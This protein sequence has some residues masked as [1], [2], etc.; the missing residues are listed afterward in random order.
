MS[1]ITSGKFL[2]KIA[3]VQ[4]GDDPDPVL[5][6]NGGQAFMRRLDP[7]RAER[8]ARRVARLLPAGTSFVLLGYDSDPPQGYS[9]DLIAGDVAKIISSRW[10][11]RATVIGISF[12][13]IVATRLV[14][15][16]PELVAKLVLLASAH[17]FSDQGHARVLA[18]IDCAERG[19]FQALVGGFVAVFRRRWLNALLRTRLWFDRNKLKQKMN[20]PQAIIRSLRAVIDETAHHGRTDLATIK[21]P[22][23]VIGGSEDQFFGGG[24]M[25]EA[26]SGMKHAQL[27]LFD[28][29]THMAPVERAKDIR[30]ILSG[31]L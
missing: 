27:K 17:R 8:D 22:T 21:T 24:A 30:A 23:L 2:D 31:F 9:L 19:D 28:Q 7:Q 25:Q 16:H 11:G 1:K 29:E 12:G 18:Q 13:G 10:H 6:L 26:A 15:R 14:I 20:E 4:M 5:I 3:F